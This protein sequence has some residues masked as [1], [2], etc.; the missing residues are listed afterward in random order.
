M[1]VT[2]VYEVDADRFVK[3]FTRHLSVFFDLSQ[4]GLRL[5]STPC[6]SSPRR[7]TKTPSI[8]TP[9][10]PTDT[11]RAWGA[12]G[13]NRASFYRGVAELIERGPHR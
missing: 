6:Q 13:Y 4:N 5:F 12:K 2:K 8:C 9:S 7:T 3:V 1:E 10:T 11:T